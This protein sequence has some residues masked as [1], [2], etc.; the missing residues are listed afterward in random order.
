MEWYYVRDGYRSGPVNAVELLRLA[1]AQSL[2]PGTLVWRD[3]LED[4]QPYRLISGTDPELRAGLPCVQCGG[5]FPTDRLV[6]LEPG[7]VCPSCKPAVL[8]KFREEISARL[9]APGQRRRHL[10]HETSLRSAGLLHILSGLLVA[11]VGLSGFWLRYLGNFRWRLPYNPGY[12]SLALLPVAGMF[13]WAGVSLYRLRSSAR[14]S[15]GLL[16]TLSLWVFPVGT[17]VH[18]YILYLIFSAKGRF[19]L[20]PA[21]QMIRELTP[22][23]RY[24]TSPVIWIGLALVVALLGY[25]IWNG[26]AG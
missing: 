11:A 12:W 22:E 9:D 8:Q 4:W 20:S 2:R 5:L 10:T 16:S 26:F 13:V 1:A 14:V 25:W 23:I 17:L 15:A 18:G 3:G 21:Y 24:R 19:V 6:P 7:P